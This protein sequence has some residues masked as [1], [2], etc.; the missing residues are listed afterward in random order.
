MAIGTSPADN[1]LGTSAPPSC[2]GGSPQSRSA[3]DSERS[4][5]RRFRR[6]PESRG[7]MTTRA[8]GGGVACGDQGIAGLFLESR[9]AFLPVNAVLD[10][11]LEAFL[12]FLFQAFCEAG[13]VGE[14]LL[15]QR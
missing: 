8:V 4:E 10:K 1:R 3:A 7:R 15:E 9:F 14:R 5:T 6:R 2:F 11:A 12:D 13:P